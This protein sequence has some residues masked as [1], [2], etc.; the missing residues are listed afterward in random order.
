MQQR[1]EK[2]EELQ[3]DNQRLTK[4]IQVLQE[5]ENK[6]QQDQASQQSSSGYFGAGFFSGNNSHQVTQMKQELEKINEDL[7]LAQEELIAK[8]QENEMVNIKIFDLEKEF[9]DK[10]K[11]FEAR[12]MELQKKQHQL[13]QVVSEREAEIVKLQAELEMLDKENQVKQ[14]NINN[15]E[16]KYLEEQNK[17]VKL[18]ERVGFQMDEHQCAYQAKFP[19]DPFSRDNTFKKSA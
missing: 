14:E 10:E 9:N 12:I 4:R 18:C 2:I 8:I 7:Q 16:A 15:M 19:M 13:E 6:R 17:W 11:K 1:A 3:L 5:L